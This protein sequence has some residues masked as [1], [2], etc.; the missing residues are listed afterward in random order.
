[1]WKLTLLLACC[2]SLCG[3]ELRTPPL[4]PGTPVKVA[5]T[6]VQSAIRTIVTIDV[7]TAIQGGGNNAEVIAYYCRELV[8]TFAAMGTNGNFTPMEV[9]RVPTPL[10]LDLSSLRT[11]ILVMYTRAYD[12]RSKGDLPPVAWLASIAETFRQSIRQGIINGGKSNIIQ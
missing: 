7:A 5:L 6:N 3:A 12:Y 4:P 8:N 11:S 10:N 9:E 1:M 2:G